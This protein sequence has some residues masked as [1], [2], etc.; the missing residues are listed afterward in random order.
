M[1]KIIKDFAAVITKT[2]WLKNIN[3]EIDKYNKLK[4][5]TKLQ[6]NLVNTLVKKYHQ[7]YGE[8]LRRR[9]KQ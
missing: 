4:E 8:D 2:R 5:K 9:E 3:R 7:I 1:R 6:Q